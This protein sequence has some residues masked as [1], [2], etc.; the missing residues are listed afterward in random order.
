M[1]SKTWPTG[2][3]ARYVY[4]ASGYL[5]QVNG[6]GTGGF[7]QTVSYEVLAMDAQGHITQY[8]QGNQVTTV[9]AYQEAT[10]RLSGQTATKAGQAT[11]NVLNHSYTYDSLG[12]L[13]TRA[14]NSPGVGTQESFSYDS[15]NRLTLNT[16]LGGA[17]SPPTTTEVKYDA[18]VISQAA[19]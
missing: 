12:N 19:Y 3:Q 9:K 2:Y 1:A 10:G 14:D 8:K 5:K 13:T 16:L 17:V 18:N 6:G 11:G 15:L 7:T 4:S